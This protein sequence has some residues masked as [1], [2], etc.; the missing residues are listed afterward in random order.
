ML[1]RDIF[2]INWYHIKLFPDSEAG[3]RFSIPDKE[4]A[5]ALRGF[6]NLSDERGP[7]RWSRRIVERVSKN[8]PL[9]KE[10][11]QNLRGVLKYAQNNLNETIQGYNDKGLRKF[12]EKYPRMS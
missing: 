7:S 5:I 4:Q 6:L 12:L 1:F 2:K 11:S 8:H 3:R 9:Y 10:S